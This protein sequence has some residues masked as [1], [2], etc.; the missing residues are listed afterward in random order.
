MNDH[1]PANNQHP[2]EGDCKDVTC[3]ECSEKFTIPENV[4]STACPN[5]GSEIELL[6]AND[7]RLAGEGAE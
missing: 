6:A 5:C 4:Y 3:H 2:D 7:A 1:Y